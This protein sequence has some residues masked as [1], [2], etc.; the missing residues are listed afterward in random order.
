VKRKR[1]RPE[2][3][4]PVGET[5]YMIENIDRQQLFSKL[6]GAGFEPRGCRTSR[7]SRVRN[8]IWERRSAPSSAP[9]RRRF[10]NAYPRS[11]SPGRAR[12]R[13]GVGHLGWLA[14]AGNGRDTLNFKDR[15]GSLRGPFGPASPRTS[16][17][18]AIGSAG[19]TPCFQK[20]DI[21]QQLGCGAVSSAVPRR[22]L[23]RFFTPCLLRGWQAAAS[24]PFTSSKGLSRAGCQRRDE[25]LQ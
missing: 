12:E 7:P 8:T 11:R 14:P 1:G 24:R 19:A 25:R 9:V 18:L 20:S 16:A 22:P 4:V 5:P 21:Q 15:R 17:H 6:G 23:Y 13:V 10:H 2:G 3:R